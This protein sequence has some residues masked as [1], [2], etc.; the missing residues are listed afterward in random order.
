M[1]PSCY[2]LTCT[3]KISVFFCVLYS[4]PPVWS[5][6]V[7]LCPGPCAPRCLGSAPFLCAGWRCWPRLFSSCPQA[8]PVRSAPRSSKICISFTTSTTEVCK[9]KRFYRRV[10]R[11]AW[12][13][14]RAHH[15]F[16]TLSL[17]L[18]SNL[19]NV[20]FDH[21][22]A[23]DILGISKDSRHRANHKITVSTNT[24]KIE[25]NLNTFLNRLF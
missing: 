24:N 9:P 17:H 6:R 4:S 2:L 5:S 7:V 19:K 25:S 15:G 12:Y 21:S 11:F 14:A 13:W 8:P 20:S 1:C 3:Y 18:R 16:T 10:F 23:E 22:L